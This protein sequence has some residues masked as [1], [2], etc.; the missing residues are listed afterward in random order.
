MSDKNY[1]RIDVAIAYKG[2]GD[3]GKYISVIFSEDVSF[4]AGDKIFFNEN[5]YKGENEKAPDFKHSRPNP[6][7]VE[8]TQDPDLLKG[9]T[10]VKAVGE[11]ELPF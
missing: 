10:T 3:Y 8:D 4:K 7:Y 5:K 11:G 1:K 9:K 6:D 2:E